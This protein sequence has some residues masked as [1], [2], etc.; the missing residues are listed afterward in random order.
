MAA[1][2]AERAQLIVEQVKRGPDAVREAAAQLDQFGSAAQRAQAQAARAAAQ[3]TAA[4]REL[5]K[6]FDEDVAGILKL[7]RTVDVT[8]QAEI[9]EFRAV[10]AAQRDIMTAAG[11]TADQFAKLAQASKTV[12]SGMKAA[13]VAGIVP[14]EAIGA[15]AA[16]AVPPTNAAA[17]AAGAFPVNRLRQGARAL[18]AISFAAQGANLEGRG[19]IIAFGRLAETMALVSQSAKF[20]GIAGGIG[21]AVTVAGALYEILDKI[22]QENIIKV[23]TGGEHVAGIGDL[24]EARAYLDQLRKI[25]DERSRQ[26][27]EAAGAGGAPFGIQLGAGGATMVTMPWLQQW[28]AVRDATK[29]A[30]QAADDYT[31]GVA[32]V[33][34]LEA[35]RDREI[36]QSSFDRRRAAAESVRQAQTEVEALGTQRESLD[37]ANETTNAYQQQSQQAAIQFEQ[38]RRAIRQSYEKYDN[39]LHLI[40]LT[41]QE[42]KARQDEYNAAADVLESRKSLLRTEMAIAQARYRTETAAGGTPGDAAVARL[43]QLREQTDDDVRKGIATRED[44]DKRYHQGARKLYWDTAKEAGKS[45]ATISDALRHSHSNDVKAIGHVADSLR[46]ILIG[47]DAAHAAV[48]SRHEFASIPKALAAHDPAAAALHAAAGVQLAAAAAFGFA[49]ALGGGGNAGGGASGGGSGGGRDVFRPDQ[50][51]A[52]G[53]GGITLILQST[54]PHGRENTR[55]TIYQIDRSRVLN[56]PIYASGLRQAS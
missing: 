29:S 54:D 21:A 33:T 23:P 43:R 39:E 27:Q 47:A 36:A 46:R 26:A 17:A 13:G 12:E 20:A 15:A 8:S 1:S 45:F 35:A 10:A 18:T 42:V 24:E 14:M 30:A 22:R 7:A 28:G 9:A 53:G 56:M 6:S 2:D 25:R 52:G 31:K 48:E 19:A 51:A 4:N 5:A 3:T 34:A 55:Q 44:A 50:G 11:G 32:H 38:Q 40:P 49:Q 16:K 41:K 37:V